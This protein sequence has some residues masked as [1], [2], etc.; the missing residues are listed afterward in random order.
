MGVDYIARKKMKKFRKVLRRG[1]RGKDKKDE[2]VVDFETGEDG[3]PVKRE[4]KKKNQASPPLFGNQSPC[5]GESRRCKIPQHISPGL[6][7]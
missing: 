4:R 5:P 6:S 3:K 1:E 2:N 7:R